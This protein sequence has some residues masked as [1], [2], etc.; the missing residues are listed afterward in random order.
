M[1]DLRKNPHLIIISRDDGEELRA[2]NPPI[3]NLPVSALSGYGRAC[4][5]LDLALNG[6][7]PGPYIN[8]ETPRRPSRLARLFCRVLGHVT[9]ETEA[10]I[11]PR[12]GRVV[13]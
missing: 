4:R 1:I 13:L 11:C 8:N 2:V 7:G 12:C 9:P 6:K 5:N 10:G 3:T